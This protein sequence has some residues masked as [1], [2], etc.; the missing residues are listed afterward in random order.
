MEIIKNLHI[1]EL[2]TLDTVVLSIC[3]QLIFV[4]P[5][6]LPQTHYYLDSA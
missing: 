5:Q 3:L 2:I 6:S 1:L 4:Q